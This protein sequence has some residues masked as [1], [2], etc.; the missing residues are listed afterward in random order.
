[1]QLLQRE[2]KTIKEAKERELERM[3]QNLSLARQGCL[4]KAAEQI[5]QMQATI[6][7]LDVKS[8]RLA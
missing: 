3:Q 6:E 4:D 8:N 7:E 1:M 2:L 5:K